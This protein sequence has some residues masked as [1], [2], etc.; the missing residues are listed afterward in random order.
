MN[1][2]NMLKKIL[3]LSITFVLCS[4]YQT[5]FENQAVKGH[6]KFHA[7]EFS[8]DSAD[9]SSIVILL[10]TECQEIKKIIEHENGENEYAIFLHYKKLRDIEKSRDES[11]E[12]RFLNNTPEDVREYMT[13]LYKYCDLEEFF[14]N[15]W[16]GLDKNEN[17]YQSSK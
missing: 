3:F 6:Q 16:I 1:K 13:I 17:L 11:A 9:I 5:Q 12:S 8:D 7:L 2:L 10:K 14:T 15:N 4:S